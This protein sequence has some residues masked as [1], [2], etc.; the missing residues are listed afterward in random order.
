MAQPNPDERPENRQMPE[1]IP[2]TPENIA[3]AVLNTPPEPDGEA[4][5]RAAERLAKQT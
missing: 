3:Q 1:R 5:L 2:D 4:V